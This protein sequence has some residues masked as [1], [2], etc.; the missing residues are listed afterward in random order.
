MLKSRKKKERID[1][2]CVATSTLKLDFEGD[3]GRTGKI[4][5]GR[6]YRA[7]SSLSNGPGIT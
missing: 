1:E 3:A 7:L 5:V 2:D 4:Y 6:S